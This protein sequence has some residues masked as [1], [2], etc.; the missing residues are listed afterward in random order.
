MVFTSPAVGMFDESCF[1][2]SDLVKVIIMTFQAVV[3]L[4][5]CSIHI[6]QRVLNA[7]TSHCQNNYKASV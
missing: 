6:F 1:L 3:F 5:T 7:L 2:A 4:E